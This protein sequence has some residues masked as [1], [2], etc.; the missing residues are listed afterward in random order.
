[1]AFR[2]I[3]DVQEE[4]EAL[5][6]ELAN[7][8]VSDD[9]ADVVILGGAPLAGLNTK[10]ADR[11]PV[12]LVDPVAA[13]VKQAEALLALGPRKAAAGTFRRPDAKSTVGLSDAL[14]AHIEHRGDGRNGVT[15]DWGQA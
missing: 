4:K 7:K 9:E 1:G 12:P 5:L 3:V 13:A 10:V 14:A 15:A 11:I 8:A 6:V 2:S